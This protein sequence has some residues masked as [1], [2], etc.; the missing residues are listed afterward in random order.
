MALDDPT[1][2]MSKSAPN[3]HSRISL[4]DDASKIKKSI[5]KSTTDSEGII[6]FDIENKPGVSNLLSIYSALTGKSI[7]DLEKDYEGH[8]Y[9]DLKKDLVEVTVDALRPIQ[10]KFEEIRNSEELDR[11]L[12]DGAERANAIAEQTMKRVR[13]HFGLGR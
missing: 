3:A 12:S 7:E 10:E 1:S 8:G 5:M 11:A 13:D 9:G 2:K 6:R 4:L